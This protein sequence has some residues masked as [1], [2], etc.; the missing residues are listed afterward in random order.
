MG[1]V[2]DNQLQPVILQLWHFLQ[3]SQ[4][5]TGPLHLPQPQLMVLLQLVR[6]SPVTGYLPVAMTGPLNTTCN[7]LSA[8]KILL[9][10]GQF[11][12]VLHKSLLYTQTESGCVTIP[13]PNN[14]KIVLHCGAHHK[15][16]LTWLSAIYC[17]LWPGINQVVCYSNH[18][19]FFLP[20]LQSIA[21]RLGM[22]CDR[23][24][25]VLTNL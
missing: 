22:V 7:N 13:F 9:Y 14:K 5:V 10:L 11:P 17:N 25:L 12:S 20:R 21:A 16:L 18:V 8:W 19:R 4:L 3:T 23:F 2:Q 1:H 6:F 24:L 15:Q